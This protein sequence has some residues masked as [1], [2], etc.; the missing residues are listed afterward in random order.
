MNDMDSFATSS[1]S[2]VPT[3]KRLVVLPP[4]AKT[5]KVR[6]MEH[7]KFSCRKRRAFKGKLNYSIPSKRVLDFEIWKWIQLKPKTVS[8]CISSMLWRSMANG[9]LQTYSSADPDECLLHIA[10]S[11]FQWRRIYAILSCHNLLK[12][13]WYSGCTSAKPAAYIETG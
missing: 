11:S 4:N 7:L 8:C 6:I 12:S 5:S 10:W 2:R 13:L 3:N 1:P 9:K